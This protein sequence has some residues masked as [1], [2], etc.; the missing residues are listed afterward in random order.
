M[1]RPRNPQSRWAQTRWAR[2]ARWAGTAGWVALGA[3]LLQLLSPAPLAP[4]SA[5][6][7]TP[8]GNEALESRYRKAAA[9]YHRLRDQPGG[10]TE[11]WRA[12]AKDFLAIHRLAPTAP[13]GADALYS[14]A[15]A[16]RQAW[17]GG[18]DWRDLSKATGT[19][20]DFT[21]RYPRNRL[22]DDSLMQM[23]R[24]LAQGYGDRAGERHA[25]ERLL[26]EYPQGDQ[27]PGARDLLR[28]LEQS[29]AAQGALA[30]TGTASPSP[31]SK[32]RGPETGKASEEKAAKP[33]LASTAKQAPLPGSLARKRVGGLNR[34]QYWTS[35]E[36][37]R[38]VLS[39]DPQV[40]YR[41]DRLDADGGSPPRLYLDFS[42]ARPDRTLKNETPVNDGVLE[43][44]RIGR[45]GADATRVVLDLAEVEKTEVRDYLLPTERKIIVDLYRPREKVRMLIASA[46]SP[47]PNRPH[48]DTQAAHPEDEGNTSAP[49]TA[50]ITPASLAMI[51]GERGKKQ[52]EA[53]Q[54]PRP[55]LSPRDL[56]PRNARPLDPSTPRPPLALKVD[57]IMLDPGHGGRD[58]GAVAFGLMEK[59]VALDIAH[60]IER[61]LAQRSPDLKVGLTRD[62]DQFI[63]LKDRP[64]L[65]KSFGA[66]LFVSIHLNASTIERFR[67]VESYFLNLT[68][69]DSALK[70]AARENDTTTESVSDLNLILADLLRD[71]NMVESSTLAQTLQESL[72]GSLRDRNARI[73]NLGVKQAPFLVLMG[74][75]MP[76]V[77]VE[78]GFV[79]NR[80]EN[81]RLRNEAYLERISEGF[82]DG[83]RQYI[84]QQDLLASRLSPDSVASRP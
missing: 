40:E 64:R 68:D 77:L 15:L 61:L 12:L 30:T 35:M 10:D 11:S 46:K 69:D 81:R 13:R 29:R 65:A 70:V 3:L 43:R 26:A 67:G 2:T 53:G 71:T 78:A 27:M 54:S 19:F 80:L 58:P 66:D 73:R 52:D 45:Q 42:N 51:S 31:P 41:H 24:L 37:T 47:G 16:H 21:T 44:I 62:D 55:D 9:T 1:M 60:R 14:A 33:S 4:G 63:A 36:W 56:S 8:P 22:A 28:T 7:G 32:P 74:A 76:S 23:A 50:I 39:I 34:V 49:P 59:H 57:A 20:R 48:P 18:G 84:E 38:V 17:R 6:A 82:Y 79:T 75:E 25:Y 5:W 83:L 72:V